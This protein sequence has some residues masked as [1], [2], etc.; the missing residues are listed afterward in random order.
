MYLE[1]SCLCLVHTL[2]P[3][4]MQTTLS[5]INALRKLKIVPVYR[6]PLSCEQ[7]LSEVNIGPNNT[8][9]MARVKRQTQASSPTEQNLRKSE[10][11]QE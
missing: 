4:H 7:L 9:K 8:V 10:E 6:T 3:S 11:L 1:I 2:T 5:Q